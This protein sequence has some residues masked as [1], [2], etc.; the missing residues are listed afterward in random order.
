MAVLSLEYEHED[1]RTGVRVIL[2]VEW[3]VGQEQAAANAT[4][5]GASTISGQIASS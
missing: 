2:R 5:E 3:P 1:I 4:M